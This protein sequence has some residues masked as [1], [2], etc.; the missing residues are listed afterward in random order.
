RMFFIILLLSAA[1]SVLLVNTIT[2]PL[3][4]LAKAA[5]MVRTGQGDAAAIPDMSERG[6]EIGEVSIA[7]RGLVRALSE[8]MTTIE[9][10]A[11]DVSHELKNPLTSMRSALETLKNIKSTNDRKELMT[12]LET[13]VRRLD[14][15]VTDISRASRLDVEL[16]RESADTFNL[17]DLLDGIVENYCLRHDMAAQEGKTL[18]RVVFDDGGFEQAIAFGNEDRLTQVVTNLIDNAISFSPGDG[19]VTIRLTHDEDNNWQVFVDDEGPG[20]PEGKTEKIFER[21][22]TERAGKE[23]FGQHSGLGLS[24]ARKIVEA[25]EGR[26][27]ATNR[28]REN[29]ILGARFILTLP[30]LSKENLQ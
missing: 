19:Q 5:E 21:F 1:L 14:R 4:R 20:I 9:R 25:H 16:A 6:D 7:L 12:I 23:L 13:D 17:V 29:D 3:R 27:S 15:L 22:Y 28:S 26:L 24:I 2:N 8:R 10:F 11:A 30:R 18:P